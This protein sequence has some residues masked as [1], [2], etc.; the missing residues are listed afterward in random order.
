MKEKVTTV[1]AKR[2]EVINAAFFYVRMKYYNA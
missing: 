2:N 1:D